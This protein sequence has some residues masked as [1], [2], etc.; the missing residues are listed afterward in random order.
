MVNSQAKVRY[1]FF[2]YIFARPKK[3]FLKLNKVPFLLSERMVTFTTV[4]L[5]APQVWTES[6]PKN[7]FV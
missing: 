4:L 3:W 5:R 6:R 2:K 7:I 1:N